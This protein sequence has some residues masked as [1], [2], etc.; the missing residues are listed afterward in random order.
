MKGLFIESNRTELQTYK[1]EERTFGTPCTWIWNTYHLFE[2]L[3]RRLPP[4]DLLSFANVFG[5]S[6]QSTFALLWHRLPFLFLRNG[7]S[8]VV[9][10]NLVFQIL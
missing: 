7:K 5:V 8:D 1:V 3:G 6:F 10:R 9:F 2:R 4:V